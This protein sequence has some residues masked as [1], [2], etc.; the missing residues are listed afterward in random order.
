[1]QLQVQQDALACAACSRLWPTREGIAS[2]R[3]TD[4]TGGDHPRPQLSAVLAEVR[5]CGWDEAVHRRLPSANRDRY[6]DIFDPRLA[7]W[8]YLLDIDGHGLALVSGSG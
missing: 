6:R 7:D 5:Q 2:F 1:M 4:A 8:F 3:Q